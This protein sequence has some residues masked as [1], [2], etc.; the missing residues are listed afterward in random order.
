M[1]K[2]RR[3]DEYKKNRAAATIFSKIPSKSSWIE[4]QYNPKIILNKHY[5]A[6]VSRVPIE[7]R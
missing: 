6:F 5:R 1:L 7:L 2:L 3:N 4:P